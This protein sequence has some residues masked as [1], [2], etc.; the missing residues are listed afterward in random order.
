MHKR[1]FWKKI[2]QNKAFTLLE[3]LVVVALIVILLAFSAL[4][5]S[6]W[7]KTFKMT[8]LNNYAKTIYLEAQNQLSAK[9][10]EG[11]LLAFY[12]EVLDE[13]IPFLDAAPKDYYEGDASWDQ[14]CYVTNFAGTNSILSQL[15]PANAYVNDMGGYYLIELNPQTGDIYSV[16]YWESGNEF[17]HNYA[18]IQSYDRDS[19][20]RESIELGY[21][22]GSSV[23]DEATISS[24][25]DLDQKVEV[26][27]AEELYLK[28]SYKATDVLKHYYTTGLTI[29]CSVY[30]EEGDAGY[31]WTT[32]VDVN[33]GKNI[34]ISN[35]R[36]EVYI[37]LD[38]IQHS[39]TQITSDIY[40]NSL[41]AGDNLTVEVHSKFSQ[42][43]YYFE[44]TSK[45][46]SGFNSL[47]AS[48]K[49]EGDTTTIYISKL[50]HLRNLDSSYYSVAGGTANYVIELTTDLDMETTECV[51]SG[52]TYVG[53]SVG[54]MVYGMSPIINTGLL[55][56]TSGTTTIDGAN[57][58]IK[59]LVITASSNEVGLF[60]ST[61]NVAF[62]NIHLVDITV[63]AGGYNN[64]GTL[65][66]IISGGSVENCGAY[67]STYFDNGTGKQYYSEQASETYGNKMEER[68][69]T[70]CVNGAENVG[71]LFG[72]VLNGATLTKTY[73]AVKVKGETNVGGFIGYA[74]SVA[75]TKSYASGDVI[76]NVINVGGFIGYSTG[77][78][79]TDAYSTS[80]IYGADIIGGLLGYTDNSRFKNCYAYG[81]VLTL[82]GTTNF[83]VN[84]D[85]TIS[86]ADGD[87]RAG[88]LLSVAGCGEN[89]ESV[90][91]TCFYMTQSL[92]NNHG[93]FDGFTE[94]AE[95]YGNLVKNELT[96]NNS[97]PYD[98]T[99]LYKEFPFDAVME[100]HYGDW[101]L[102]YLVNTSLV[103]YEKYANGSYGYYC[104]TTL[105]KDDGSIADGYV[106]VLNTL[107]NTECIEDGYALLSRYYL[108][109]FDYELQIGS[110]GTTDISG[111]VTVEN[112]Y[113]AGRT[114]DIAV[115]LRQQ[116]FLE[117][118]AYEPIEGSTE[119]DYSA[120]YSGKAVKDI[121]SV[122]GMY[123][124]QLPYNL[125]CTDRYYVTNFYDKFIV[126]NGIEKTSSGEKTPVIGGTSAT[127]GVS[128]FYCP[129][130]A[131][132]AVNP[133]TSGDD[134]S[135]LKNPAKVY[136]RSARQLNAL[137]R[138]PYY[139]NEEGG[140][141]D[142][143]TYVQ[144]VDINF[145]S[146]VKTYC[147]EGFNLMD[148]SVEN[149]VRNVPIGMPSY[150]DTYKQFQNTYD[151]QCN[152]IIDYCLDSDQQFVGL[153]GETKGATLK[154]IVMVVSS[155]GAGRVVSRDFYDESG[156]GNHKRGGLGALVGLLY[157]ENNT[158][159][160]CVAAGYDVIYVLKNEPPSG[161]NITVGVAVGGLVGFSM[162]N[163]SN[164]AAENDILFQLECDYSKNTG[165][166][167]LGGLAGSFFYGNL[168]NS[169]S[170]GTIRI[171]GGDTY[172]LGR[173]RV[174]GLC[175]GFLQTGDG[176]SSISSNSTIYYQ[177]L[178]TYTEIDDS[179]WN[180]KSSFS[181]FIPTVG[182]L[183]CTNPLNQ[184]YLTGWSTKCFVKDLGWKT[185]TSNSYYLSSVITEEMEEKVDDETKEYYQY[186]KKFVL[187]LLKTV[188]H[189]Q[190]C[191]SI[192]YEDLLNMTGTYSLQAVD[193]YP[194]AEEL[195]G[196]DYPFPEFITDANGNLVHYGDWPTK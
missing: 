167:F 73:S 132:T 163:I 63:N 5:I 33:A 129:H 112:Q 54:R 186:Y 144:E 71:G 77:I 43:A 174:G 185:D 154:N 168:S 9:E 66:G 68:Y 98:A 15:I 97:Y 14:L 172:E 119:S 38:S 166:V 11:G 105:T 94:L 91:N 92:Y 51:W 26:I 58:L 10:V 135:Q 190:T 90:D 37:L 23:L 157:E 130:Y 125:Q 101:A 104:V 178:Y 100:H 44:Q 137:G 55:K 80:D 34:T 96:A 1:I 69:D 41:T 150:S 22:G 108:E 194:Y 177:N 171:I 93:E 187:L 42:G 29:E 156:D 143:M 159:T 107:R 27:N 89:T 193:S 6:G 18:D 146:Y 164:C 48:K 75:I 142:E 36:L 127:E 180:I 184:T 61:E 176:D 145:G 74:D 169:Y 114:S 64:V 133:G 118:K 140:M 28:I 86:A 62:K 106:W 2:K 81:E 181:Q 76:G 46:D 40:G 25:F 149:P 60:A 20:T 95:G 83:D 120:D 99:L 160:N 31:V 88:G 85:G 52:D 165:T 72:K 138:Y 126:Y 57:K 162:S 17:I 45:I 136:V 56:N 141:A 111:T 4:S 155:D 128:F 79:V 191:E 49:V 32:E 123:L 78:T 170:G 35:G 3:M 7:V 152:K 109:K 13:G 175:P 131:K 124:Y 65:A 21:Y 188:T 182:T 189:E 103:Y 195:Q 173:L 161:K 122:S 139:W 30:D 39:F 47:F 82:A 151:G 147:G 158:V 16:F 183:C 24:P 70:F 67:L 134:D 148:T 87:I 19:D 116:G 196:Q 50:R 59:N 121:F 115:L 84:N 8:E 53:S 113:E 102:Q 192:S 110:T 12:G 153:F 179:V 117:F